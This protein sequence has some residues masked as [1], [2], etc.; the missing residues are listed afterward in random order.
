MQ[1][2]TR[3]SSLLFYSETNVTLNVLKADYLLTLIERPILGIVE[4]TKTC[5]TKIIE[6]YD[7][8][9]NHLYTGQVW[10][11]DGKT[12]QLANDSVFLVAGQLPRSPTNGEM[13][14]QKGNQTIDV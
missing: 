1:G 3:N 13:V 11:V 10:Y 4:T 14:K 7:K 12:C 8:Y 2:Q 5:F 6:D 9:S